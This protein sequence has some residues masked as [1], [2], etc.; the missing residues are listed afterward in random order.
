LVGVSLDNNIIVYASKWVNINVSELNIDYLTKDSFL[1]GKANDKIFFPTYFY[2]NNSKGLRLHAFGAT[3]KKWETNI[4]YQGVPN[5]YYNFDYINWISDEQTSKSYIYVGG[6]ANLTI[7]DSNNL[8]WINGTSNPQ[9]LLQGILGS[10]Q[11]IVKYHSF[12]QVLPAS[13][14]IFYIGGGISGSSFGSSLTI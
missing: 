14:K 3:L 9:N 12:V 2:S 6:D 5:D 10:S 11:I 7:F 13:D 1:G 8:A 4:S